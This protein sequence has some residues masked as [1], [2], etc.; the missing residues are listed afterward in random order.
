MEEKRCLEH[1]KIEKTMRDEL[2]L[3]ELWSYGYGKSAG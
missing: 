1:G 3:R 2:V